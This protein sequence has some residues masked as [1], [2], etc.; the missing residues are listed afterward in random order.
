MA[1]PV[2]EVMARIHYEAERSRAENP[3]LLSPWEKLDDGDKQG[4][5]A[6][7]AE[8]SRFFNMF[9]IT[10]R[11]VDDGVAMVEVRKAKHAQPPPIVVPTNKPHFTGQMCQSCSSLNTIQNGKCLLCLDCKASGEC[12]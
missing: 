8:V 7:M 4:R 10:L 9:G 6:D 12:S 1:I 2:T 11:V 3:N 5:M